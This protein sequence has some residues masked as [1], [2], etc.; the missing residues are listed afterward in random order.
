MPFLNLTFV[1]CSA[2]LFSCSM[3]FQRQP[4]PEV[5]LRAAPTREEADL[6]ARA[7]WEVRVGL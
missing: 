6:Y 7:Q 4:V 2:P 3:S 1:S 5:V